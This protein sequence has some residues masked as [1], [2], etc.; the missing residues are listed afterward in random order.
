MTSHLFVRWPNAWLLFSS[1]VWQT[2]LVLGTHKPFCSPP[3]GNVSLPMRKYMN[4]L[5]LSVSP[6]QI[7]DLVTVRAFW[8]TPIP[9]A[10]SVAAQHTPPLSFSQESNTGQKW[11]S[12]QCELTKCEAPWSKF[13]FGT[14]FWFDS[15]CFNVE[16]WTC[17]LCWLVPYR[18]P[19]SH[20]AWK[21]CIRGWWTRIWTLYRHLSPQVLRELHLWVFQKILWPQKWH[22][23]KNKQLLHAEN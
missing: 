22:W 15:M 6:T 10:H 21:P 4:L 9:S 1:C 12:G 17:M 23:N 20:L 14:C 5:S 16:G 19:W 2:G 8:D 7:L 18:S 13:A 11:M 3:S